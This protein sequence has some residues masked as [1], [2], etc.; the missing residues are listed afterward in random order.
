LMEKGKDG[1]EWPGYKA[2]KKLWFTEGQTYHP[3]NATKLFLGYWFEKVKELQSKKTFDRNKD[4]KIDARDIFPLTEEN[5]S[6]V[7]K[8]FNWWND[9]AKKLSKNYKNS[10]EIMKNSSIPHH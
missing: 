2:R 3:K 10:K 5:I 9:Y 1:Y 7:G 8:V 4:G 6:I